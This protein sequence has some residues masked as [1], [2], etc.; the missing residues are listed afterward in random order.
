MESSPWTANDPASNTFSGTNREVL[1][2]GFRTRIHGIDPGH[3]GNDDWTAG[4][5]AENG[6][7]S[8]SPFRC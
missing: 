2:L 1:R 8:L 6:L 4:V 3:I 7:P 5:F